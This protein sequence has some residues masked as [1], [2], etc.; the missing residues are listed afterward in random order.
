MNNKR[1]IP[2][3][4]ILI[5]TLNSERVL[6]ECLAS[7]KSQDYPGEKIELIIA[8]GGSRDKTLE[9]A[10]SYKAKIINNHLITA[11]AGKAAALKNA[12]GD[13][14]A[15]I[16]SDNILPQKDWL[17]LMLKPFEDPEIVGSEP[18]EYTWRKKDGFITR[19]SAL[20]GVNDPLALF[21]GN[22][23]R[24]SFLTGRWTDLPIK[25]EDR[26]SWLKITVTGDAI[27]TLG[28]NGTIFR[29]SILV[30]EFNSQSNT[31]YLVDIDMIAN[32][33][34]KKPLFFAKVKIGII[35]LYCGSSIKTFIRKQRRRIKDFLFYSRK[36]LR[37][38]PWEE[39]KKRKILLF[40]ISCITII[41]LLYQ[42][43]KG[44]YKKPDP[45]WFFHP[46]ACW[47]TLVIYTFETIKSFFRLEASKRNDWK[48]II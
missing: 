16:D 35:H 44:Y 8:D 47:I 15:M 27:P 40:V 1:N 23:D 7:I 31:D 42:T 5:P 39:Q 28:A 12:H 34:R 9:I 17:T 24:R 33:A 14:V 3:I 10:K 26:K 46:F 22:Y 13:L 38:Y 43:L 37:T 4:S 25:Q 41:P 18:W 6:K 45:A 2:L 48:A 30:K 29:R 36:G 20:T 19:Y 32:L 11:E 21:I